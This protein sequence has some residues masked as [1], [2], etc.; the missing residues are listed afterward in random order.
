MVSKASDDLPDPDR[1]VKTTSLSR[2]IDSVTFLRLCSRA[3]RIVIWSIGIRTLRYSFSRVTAN[4]ALPVATSR[5]SPP[6]TRHSAT[7]VRRPAWITWPRARRSSPTLAALMKLSL[8]SKLMARTTPGFSVRTDRPMAESASVLIIPPWTKPEWLAMSSV[9]VI[10]TTA[11]PSPVSTSRMPSHA[12]A[13]DGAACVMSLTALALRHGHAG[14]GRARDEPA[15]VVENI[16]RAEQQRLLHLDDATHGAKPSLDY[17]PQEVDRQLDGRVPQ[18]IFLE[19]GQRHPHRRVSDLRDDAA[20]HD[21]AAVPVL[22]PRLQLQ[23]HAAGLGFGDARAQRLHPSG[24]LG[25]KQR[26]RA[27]HA[28]HGPRR[29][30]LQFRTVV[31]CFGAAAI[32]RATSESSSLTDSS[33]D[34]RLR[35]AM[36]RSRT[37]AASSNWS[38][39]DNRRISFSRSRTIASKS[40]RGTPAPII[41]STAS[42]WMS[43]SLR[44]IA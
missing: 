37:R 40:S 41:S 19:R 31:R 10:S 4:V 9:V 34:S 25:R 30:F 22:R 7:T 13:R 44:S 5:P 18:A 14:G 43:L 27:V 17:G 2:G 8:R 21:P 6:S 1:P 36:I 16:R 38:S 35:S 29:V 26:L 15:L 32:A 42:A 3:P 23:H 33:P 11:V 12:Q 28:L 20:L 24:G 39:F